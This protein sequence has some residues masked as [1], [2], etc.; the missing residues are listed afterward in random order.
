MRT[1][2]ACLLLAVCGYS[3]TTT[4]NWTDKAEFDL[5]Q[6]VQQ[7]PTADEKVKLLLEWK[8]LYP[9]SDMSGLRLVLLV[10]AYDRQ[11]RPE[12][13]FA[14]ARELLNS[15]PGNLSGLHAVCK[16]APR[17]ENP[18]ADAAGFVKK[19]AT[20]LL[21]RL[22]EVLPEQTT[23]RNLNSLWDSV[24]TGKPARTE[25]TPD[26]RRMEQ[27]AE[28]EQIARQALAWADKRP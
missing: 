19:A 18:S 2:L 16:W 28:V 24:E 20:E 5:A 12:E 17:L 13:T 14:A 26:Q 9:K 25:K 6:R 27:R 3:Q 10:Q 7:A 23:R 1:C 22:D 4:K 11:G 8:A 21:S 15:D